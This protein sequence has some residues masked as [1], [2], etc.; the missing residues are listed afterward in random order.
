MSTET[1]YGL[2]E[3]RKKSR[4]KEKAKLSKNYILPLELMSNW[5]NCSVV[6]DMVISDDIATTEFPASTRN[7]I[8]TVTNEL[9]ENAVKYSYDRHKLVTL[10]FNNFSS[11]I[12]IE[13]SNVAHAK[14]IKYLKQLV[15]NLKSRNLDDLYYEQ[16]ERA[17][18]QSDNTSGLGFLGI[19]KDYGAK[20]GIKIQSRPTSV[21]KRHNVTY[22][23]FVKIS[24]HKDALIF[25]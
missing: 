17:I 8:S 9:L 2:Y 20:L 5:R 3:T 13:T 19:I 24:L 22:D 7:I 6:S 4:K 16:L 23:V 11:D 10:S 1:V 18:T 25:A 14:S 15:S 12:T 21:R